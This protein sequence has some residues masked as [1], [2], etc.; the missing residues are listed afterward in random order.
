[1]L[2]HLPSAYWV[3]WFPASVLATLGI[4]GILW[5][6]IEAFVVTKRAIP[7]LLKAAEQL[8]ENGGS[9]MR[10]KLNAVHTEQRRVAS[11]LTRNT[12]RTDR[13]LARLEV[14]VGIVENDD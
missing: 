8:E 6:G 13:R 5:K 11:E 3:T 12:R 7:K 1:M 2:A 14:K 9:S 4:L 10:D